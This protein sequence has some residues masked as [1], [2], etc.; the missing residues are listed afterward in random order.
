MVTLL[1]SDEVKI[2]IL[3]ILSDKKD[4]S[5]NELATK[6]RINSVTVQRNCLFLRYL[7]LLS[8]SAN[9]AQK[10]KTYRVTSLGLQILELLKKSYHRKA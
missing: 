9:K 3:N 5:T 2:R 8:I 6:C 7:G 4:H 1:K 10:I